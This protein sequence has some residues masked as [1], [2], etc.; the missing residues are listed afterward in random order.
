M[1]PVRECTAARLDDL[2][3]ELGGTVGVCARNVATGVTIAHHADERFPLASVFKIAVMV[4]VMRQVDRGALRLDERLTLTEADKSPGSTLIHCHPGLAMT[5]RDL[6]Y[7]MIT[8]SDNTATDMLWRRVG[9]DSVNAAMRTLGLTDIDCS[10]PD[11]EYFLMSCGAGSDWQGLDGAGVVARWREFEAAGSTG[12]ALRRLLDENAGLDG[13]AFRRLYDQRWGYAG[14][15]DYDDGFTIDQALDNQGT[16]RDVMELLAMIAEGRCAS[17]PSCRLMVEVMSR[18]E[19]REKIPAGLPPGLLIANKTG[20]VSGTSN[21]A[22]LVYTREKVPLV[23]VV[24]CKGLS[25][26]ATA[27]APQVIARIAACLY[28]HLAG[29]E[30]GDGVATDR[31]AASEHGIAPG[32]GPFSGPGGEVPT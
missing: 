15:R 4:E 23:M 13:A 18:Q 24:F 28:E 19:W 25:L 9:L 16:P 10:L 29:G 1:D 14:E 17:A 11:R 21:D 22:A 8:L 12:A 7:L 26:A 31:G 30:A 20:G 27:R 6:L 3:A 5:V 32:R 2:G